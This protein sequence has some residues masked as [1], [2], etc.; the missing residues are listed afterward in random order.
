M[1]NH[2][3]YIGCPV[4]ACEHWRGSLYTAKAARSQWL[5]QY[6]SVFPTVE[7]NS[8]FYALPSHETV[9]KWCE[10][11]QPGFE[12]CFKF[13]KAITHDLQLQNCEGHRNAFLQILEIA[14]KADRLGPA[15]LQLPP[16]FSARLFFALEK[17]LTNWPTDFPVAVEVRHLDWFDEGPHEAELNQLLEHLAMDRCLFDSRALFSRPPDDEIEKISQGRKPRSPLRTTVTSKR[18]MVRMVGRN[19]EEQ[20]FD[21]WAE[22]ADVVSIWIE[23]GLNPY[24]FT[25]APDDRF[26][27]DLG[28]LLWDMV[29]QRSDVEAMPKWPGLDD[30]SRRQQS[31][32]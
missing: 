10:L 12:F 24:V 15:F 28:R 21:W 3:F 32:F 26:A 19:T 7:V 25:H 6:S 22:W 11:T 30:P 29:C 31:L 27:P 16:R 4:W 14:A 13:P 18:P 9:Q 2:S 1:P 8:T 17:F 5:E 20:V 23:Q